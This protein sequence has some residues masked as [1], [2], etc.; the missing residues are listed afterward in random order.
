MKW[1]LKHFMEINNYPKIIKEQVEIVSKILKEQFDFL[2]DLGYQFN[3]IKNKT[4]GN[5]VKYITLWVFINKSINQSVVFYY[6]PL[7][8]DNKYVN[9]ITVKLYK[10]STTIYENLLEFDYFLSDRYPRLDLK[11][12]NFPMKN[13]QSSFKDNFELSISNYA[14]L[15]QTVGLNLLTQKEWANNLKFDYGLLDNFLYDENIEKEIYEDVPS[16]NIYTLDE[17]LKKI[18][19]LEGEE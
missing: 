8:V 11:K 4:E 16:E 15:L 3:E 9:L 19:G 12:L 18:E 10:P 13:N 17:L 5:T 7:D 1:K 14:V 2:S 6:Q